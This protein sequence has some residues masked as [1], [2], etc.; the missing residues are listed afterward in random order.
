LVT[1]GENVPLD[2]KYND[3]QI[4]VMEDIEDQKREPW[5]DEEV[6][7]TSEQVMNQIIQKLN[8]TKNQMEDINTD[9]KG[10]RDNLVEQM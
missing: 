8:Y 7:I 5:C 4:K 10:A 2:A 3:C 1:R 9:N 6:Y